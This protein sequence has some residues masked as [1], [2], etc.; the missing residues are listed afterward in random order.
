[1]WQTF[2]DMIRKTSVLSYV[3]DTIFNLYSVVWDTALATFPKIRKAESLPDPQSH[4]RA[5][6]SNMLR[7][8]HQPCAYASH[9]SLQL[10]QSAKTPDLTLKTEVQ[11]SAYKL[12]AAAL[13][14]Q[15][16]KLI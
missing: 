5:A 2:G 16:Q 9:C 10:V 8:L 14:D 4:L 1:M 13:A 3:F 11:Q 6:S 12:D 15:C 7:D